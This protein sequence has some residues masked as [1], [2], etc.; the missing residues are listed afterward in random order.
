MNYK[1]K[2]EL[3]KTDPFFDDA[4]HAELAALTDEK[5]IEDRFYRDLEFGTG[6]AR[7][8]MGAG[9]NRFNSYN[10]RRI[11]TGFANY[12]LRQFGED[13]KKRGVAV[14][15]DTRNNSSVYAKQTALTFCAAGI[16]AYLYTITCSTPMLSFTVRQLNCV[17]GVNVTASHNPKEYN[18]YKAYDETG[19]QLFPYTADEVIAEVDKVDITKTVIMDEA[20]AVEKGLLK[21]IGEEMMDRYVEAIKGEANPAVG[22]IWNGGD[23][24]KAELL[25]S[26]YK[27]SLILAKENSCHSIGF[28]VISSGI[29]GYPKD[30]AWKIAVQ[31]C[32]DFINENSDYLIN[33]IFA[34]LSHRS[35][36]L[37][38]KT[39]AEIAGL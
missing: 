12:L 6:G 33:I 34:V 35:K 18:G 26:A 21:Y 7:G 8:L 20:E 14:S 30:E 25:Y 1:E 27:K 11:S 38:E 39:I 3:W 37:G 31:A 2:Y 13:A 22:P 5:E 32:N 10:A 24:N 16:P 36:E 9:T 28:P 17:G 4:T 19:C 15:Y 23:S 29:Y